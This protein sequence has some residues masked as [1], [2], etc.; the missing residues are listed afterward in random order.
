[1]SD[2]RHPAMRHAHRRVDARSRA[3]ASALH[4]WL[5]RFASI[6]VPEEI[7]R[8]LAQHLAKA[9]YGAGLDDD[10][11]RI[12]ELYGLRQMRDAAGNATDEALPPSAVDEFL[13]VKE[14]KLTGLMDS[15]REVITE[16]VRGIIQDALAQDPQPSPGEIARRIRLTY[17]S[18]EDQGQDAPFVISSE[19]AALIARTELTQAENTGI[20]EGYK[21]SGVKQIEWLAYHDGR[22]G[23][24]HHEDMDGEIIDVGGYFKT[25]LGN[26]LRYPGD[27]LAPIE[28]TANC[29]CTVAAARQRH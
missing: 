10:L 1:M 24:R 8:Q 15:T 21:A 9:D 23:E 5:R 14:I 29:R 26:K 22:S 13:A 2:N 25:P 7:H 20:V 16:G 11:R 6:I 18:P 28:D 12:L 4:L 19:R 27:P 3:M 17:L